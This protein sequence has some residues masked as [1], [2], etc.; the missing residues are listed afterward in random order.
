MPTCPCPLSCTKPSPETPRELVEKPRHIG[1]EIL[2]RI[3]YIYIGIVVQ[4]TLA[5]EGPE[6]ELVTRVLVLEIPREIN[7]VE[8]LGRT[9]R[10][11][12]V[13]AHEQAEILVLKPHLRRKTHT[14]HGLRWSPV[15]HLGVLSVVEKAK[16]PRLPFKRLRVRPGWRKQQEKRK[17][18]KQPS[19]LSGY[20]SRSHHHWINQRQKY[21]KNGGGVSPQAIRFWRTARQE[22]KALRSVHPVPRLSPFPI[23]S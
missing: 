4:Q 7:L 20:R 10:S 13:R 21:N 18:P 9:E 1:P 19:P 14:E 3:P 15:F 22:A 12:Q 17:A 2:E 6:Q 8:I 5:G 23:S 11:E 16:R